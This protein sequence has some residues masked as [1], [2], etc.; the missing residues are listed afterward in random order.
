M[1]KKIRGIGPSTRWRGLVETSGEAVHCIAHFPAFNRIV[2]SRVQFPL[3]SYQIRAS[4]RCT[5]VLWPIL[6]LWP[7]YIMYG[8]SSQLIYAYMF[9]SLMSPGNRSSFG[10]RKLWRIY[11]AVENTMLTT[12]VDVF[13]GNQ[14]LSTLRN[15]FPSVCHNNVTTMFIFCL[16]HLM[17]IILNKITQLLLKH[18]YNIFQP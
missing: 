16:Q 12:F 15:Q 3:F 7:M 2:Y 1:I 18:C 10:K 4:T 14:M 5:G 9:N 11:T 6:D 8:L 17:W 13:G